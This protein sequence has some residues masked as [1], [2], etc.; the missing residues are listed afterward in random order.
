MQKVLPLFAFALLG[1]LALSATP[2]SSVP[3]PAEEPIQ[4]GAPVCLVGGPLDDGA[5]G[6]WSTL[7]FVFTDKKGALYIGASAHNFGAV[8]DRARIRGE[9]SSF[10]TVVFD[11]DTVD[12]LHPGDPP[13]VNGTDFALIRIDKRRQKDVQPSVR[14]F[15]GPTGVARPSGTRLGDAISAFGQGRPDL[16]HP[17]GPRTG[18]LL[19]DSNRVFSSTVPE[20]AGDSGM[21][22]VHAPTGR[23]LGVNAICLC[24]GGPGA[25]PTV[26]RIL[27]RLAD[28]GFR[29]QL[30]LAP[31]P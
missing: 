6:A 17:K 31:A 19:A 23:A 2:V 4:P 3:L 10:G 28:A 29:L 14:V 30:V 26:G 7:N 5:C 18:R 12:F 20:F 16:E 21:P 25:Y 9:P 1:A 13:N 27:D 8:G 11:D 22:Y 15:G 24:E